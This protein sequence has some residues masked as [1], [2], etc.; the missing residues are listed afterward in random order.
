[1]IHHKPRLAQTTDHEFRDGGVVFDEQRSHRGIIGRMEREGF[2]R[3][4]PL[5]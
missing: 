1:M 4:G 5:A 2:S 3:A